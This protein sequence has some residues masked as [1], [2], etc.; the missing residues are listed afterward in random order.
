V[1]SLKSDVEHFNLE[2]IEASCEGGWNE[3]VTKY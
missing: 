3:Q 2:D 1:H